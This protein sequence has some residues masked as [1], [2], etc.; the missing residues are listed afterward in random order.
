MANRSKTREEAAQGSPAAAQEAQSQA[1]GQAA[2]PVDRMAQARAARTDANGVR[3]PK[4]MRSLYLVRDNGPTA[5]ATIVKR[6]PNKYRLRKWLAVALDIDPTMSGKLRVIK[7]R[8][9][10]LEETIA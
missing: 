6:F 5:S 7:G 10:S 2:P 4:V 3:K 1:E 9:L 8:E